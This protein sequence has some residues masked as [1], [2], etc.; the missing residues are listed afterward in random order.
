LD[1]LTAEVDEA[2]KIRHDQP[3]PAPHL[4]VGALHATIYL[5]TPQ[6]T[7]LRHQIFIAKPKV[8]V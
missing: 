5:V 7:T 1:L 6:D 8:V 4:A 3:N 2:Q